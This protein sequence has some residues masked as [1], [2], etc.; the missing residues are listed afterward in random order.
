[1]AGED[2]HLWSAEPLGHLDPLLDLRDLALPPRGGRA[3]KVIVDAD[4]GDGETEIGG[5]PP[6]RLEVGV[7][8][9]GKVDVLQLDSLNTERARAVPEEFDL[10]HRS[11]IEGAVEA[12]ADPPELHGHSSR[13]SRLRPP[14]VARS[15]ERSGGGGGHLPEP[16][17]AECP[18]SSRS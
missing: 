12:A 9:L 16:P 4:P 17:Q 13:S 2:T 18:A 6:E 15:P 5:G 8:R 11:R 7:A 3:A 10:V 14:A 1:M